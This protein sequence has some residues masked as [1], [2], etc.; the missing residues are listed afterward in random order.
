MLPSPTGSNEFLLL[1]PKQGPT[2]QLLTQRITMNMDGRQH[3]FLVITRIERDVIKSVA[4][5]PTGQQL[6]LLEYGGDGIKQ[7]LSG[8]VGLPGKDII[9]IQQFA[10][11][12]KAIIQEQYSVE[13][14]WMVVL[15][16]F[17]RQLIVNG[18]EILTVNYSDNAM[19]IIHHQ[20]RY[21]MEIET[22]E[23]KWL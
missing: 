23:R 12:P 9:A 3:Q 15:Q 19:Q 2:P 21:I 5:L 7:R 22:M 10:L 18:A 1:S 13:R 16:P 8:Y 14:G 6:Y 20:D 4:L 11:W 17:A